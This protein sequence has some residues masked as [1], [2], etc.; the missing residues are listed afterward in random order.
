M[1]HKKQK[2]KQIQKE[3]NKQNY[4]QKTTKPP[5]Q[6]T[7]KQNKKTKPNQTKPTTIGMENTARQYLKPLTETHA[8]LKSWPC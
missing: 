4:K 1:I 8:G 3:T 2:Q 5:N 6:L 7:N